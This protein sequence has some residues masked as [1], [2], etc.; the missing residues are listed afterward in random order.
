[1]NAHSFNR[2]F[3]VRQEKNHIAF[4]HVN[5]ENLSLIVHFHVGSLSPQVNGKIA[6]FPSLPKHAPIRRLDN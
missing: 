4:D 5:I 6:V 1:M 2:Q 3:L